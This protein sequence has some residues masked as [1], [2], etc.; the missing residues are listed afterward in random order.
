VNDRY[1]AG[2]AGHG[3]G[4]YELVGYDEYGQPVYRQVP[5]Q[6]APNGSYDP[7]GRQQ[8]DYGYDPYAAGTQ[9]PAPPYGS[10]DTGQQ[11]PATAYPGYDAHPGYDPYGT[12]A[13]GHQAHPGYDPYGQ[14]ASSGPQPR[15]AEQTAHIP[16][17]AGPA[18]D[19]RHDP[20]AGPRTDEPAHDPYAELRGDEPA[21]DP[22]GE[23]RPEDGRPDPYAELA[24]DDTPGE[25]DYRTEQFAF[26]EEPDGDSEDVIDWLKFTENRTERREEARPTAFPGPR[27][28]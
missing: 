21:H 7:Y 8:Q 27:N 25:P 17:Q 4:P 18:D 26:V 11:P 15:V 19:A 22:Y 3:A 24:A 2:D 13:P 20:Y 1:D 12:Q 5:A 10:Y 9:Q 6:Q 28:G 23:P 16:Q 14:A